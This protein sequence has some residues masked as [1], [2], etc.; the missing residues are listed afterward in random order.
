M[1]DS[2]QDDQARRFRSPPYPAWNLAKA[3]DRAKALYGKAIH[4]PV[5]IS[6]LADAWGYGVKSS[7][8]TATAATLNQFGLLNGQGAGQKRRYQLTDTAIRIIRDADP[9]S[10]K[11]AVAIKTAALSPQIYRELWETF[12]TATDVSDVVIRNF[13]TLDR[14]EAGKA[15]YG[16]SAADDLISTY[17]ETLAFAGI[18]DA[19]EPL[20]EAEDEVEEEGHV[21]RK[22][23]EGQ[24]SKDAGTSIG[25]HESP[26]PLPPPPPF[27]PADQRQTSLEVGER[28]LVAGLLS[29]E[30]TFRVIVSGPVG[31]KE[32][33]RLI[34][35]LELDKEIIADGD[36]E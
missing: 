33:E 17:K 30:A 10:E 5:S 27:V 34:K 29:K 19:D 31:V 22:T 1:A 36:G 15:P 8:L 9:S 12:G 24:A 4:H 14:S 16:D 32:I 3:V 35:K 7:G 6:V 25:G 28:E 26:P 23:L 18:K 13:L 2:E 20:E 21:L 11:R